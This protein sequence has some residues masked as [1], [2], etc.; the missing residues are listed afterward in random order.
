MLAAFGWVGKAPNGVRK[1]KI[2]MVIS[3]DENL[4]KH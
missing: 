3:K 1:R 4:K 2:Q